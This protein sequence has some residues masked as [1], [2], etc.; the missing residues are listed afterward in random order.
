M[1]KK[2]IVSLAVVI[3]IIFS[4]NLIVLAE[5][6][7]EK[8]VRAENQNVQNEISETMEE[9]DYIQCEGVS[10]ETENEVHASTEDEK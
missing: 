9:N 2:R 10:T 8:P 1:L 7:S 6:I 3:T 4:N 5:N